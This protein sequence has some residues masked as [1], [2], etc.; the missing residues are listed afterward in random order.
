MDFLEDALSSDASL[1]ADFRVV[2]FHNPPFTNAR[3]DNH[4]VGSLSAQADWVPLFED[5]D[6]DLVIGG[7]YHSYQRGTNNGVTYLVVG[8][9]GGYLDDRTVELYDFFDV[10]SLTNHYAVMEV[11]GTTLTWTAYNTDEAEIDTF[12]LTAG[13]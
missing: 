12:T 9:G 1:L 11:N 3:H 6:V 13:E 4:Q 8:G 10:V 5:Y 2:A 7:H